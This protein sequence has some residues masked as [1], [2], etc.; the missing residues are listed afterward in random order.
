MMC[1]KSMIRFL[2]VFGFLFISVFHS[3]ELQNIHEYIESTA[4]HALEILCLPDCIRPTYRKLLH[5]AGLLREDG[6]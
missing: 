4:A 6:Q 2:S 5:E 3:R 1:F